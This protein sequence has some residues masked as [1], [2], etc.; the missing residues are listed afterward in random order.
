MTFREL[1][2]KLS[3]LGA[4][5]IGRSKRTDFGK[6]PLVTVYFTTDKSVVFPRKLE[7]VGSIVLASADDSQKINSEQ[8]KALLRHLK[9]SKS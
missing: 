6:K 2:E 9:L 3:E 5:E 1:K 7:T 4:R 8:Y